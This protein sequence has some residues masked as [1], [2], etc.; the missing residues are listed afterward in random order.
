VEGFSQDKAETLHPYPSTNHAIHLE[1]RYN[2]PYGPNYNLSEFESRTL[3]TVIE[4]NLANRSGQ[5]SSW[6]AAAPIFIAKRW[7]EG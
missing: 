1:P 4:A 2:L 3:K 7:N 6:L 5:Q